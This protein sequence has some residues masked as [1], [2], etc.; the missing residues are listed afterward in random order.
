MFTNK[1]GFT[2]IELLV[3]VLIIGIL[4]AIAVPQYQKAVAKSRMSEAASMLKAIR[5]A[6]EVYYL[7]HGQ[8]TANLNDLDISIPQDQIGANWW[9]SDASRKSTYIYSCHPTSLGD[10]VAIANDSNNLPR[11]QIWC[12]HTE[13]GS[14]LLCVSATK[15]SLAAQICKELSVDKIDLHAEQ[16]T[17]GTSYK[18]Y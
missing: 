8:Y 4:A 13:L 9:A 12:S 5:Q 1:K 17:G 2:L 3:V 18:I 7:S 6:Q 10:C 14:T 16:T 15:T 11:L